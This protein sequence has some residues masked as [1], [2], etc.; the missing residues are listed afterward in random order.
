[1]SESQASP[2]LES[3]ASSQAP[4]PVTGAPNAPRYGT[5][6]PN[7]IFV[8]GI[9]FGQTSDAELRNFFSA[10]GHVKEA[11]IIADRA[12]VSKGYGFITFETAEEA[13]RILKEHA[14]SLVF[15]EKKLNIGQAIRKQP[16]KYPKDVDP[17]LIPSGMVFH[18]PS[19]AYSYTYHNGVAY[20]NPGGD[21]QSA[22][23]PVQTTIATHHHPQQTQPQYAPYTVPFMLPPPGPQ[24]YMTNQHQQFAFQQPQPVRQTAPQ[25]QTQWRWVPAQAPPAAAVNGSMLPVSPI[26]PSPPQPHSHEVIYQQ[27]HHYQSPE[28]TEVPIMEPSP[29]EGTTVVQT[30]EHS[31][32]PT[33]VITRHQPYIGTVSELQGTY[34]TSYDPNSIPNSIVQ[35]VTP[36]FTGKR[37]IKMPRRGDRAVKTIRTDIPG[38]PGT[39]PIG[40][41]T[42]MMAA[43]P[44]MDEAMMMAGPTQ[45]GNSTHMGNAT[46]VSGGGD[47]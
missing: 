21:V 28:I 23:H 7:R 29:A 2:T 19:G 37:P 41:P 32:M 5:I 44:R 22:S 26:Y 45:Y 16:I 10:Y 3:A 36:K 47:N 40:Y 31:N 38:Q 17:A 1:M 25:Y 15:K 14:N 27:A 24:H 12:G 42:M 33:Q 43:P 11:K 35:K 9:A 6:I 8:G 46:H 20:F 30:G 39:S 4:S 13:H 34:T 18:S